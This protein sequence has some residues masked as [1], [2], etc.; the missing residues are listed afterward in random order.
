MVDTS[1]LS[2]YNTDPMDLSRY[3]DE[4]IKEPLLGKEEERDLFLELS[5]E[6]LPESRKKQIKDRI[7]RSNLRFV[8]KE[9]KRFSKSDP[10]LFEELISAGNEGLLVG[11]EKY[12]PDSGYRFLTYAGWWVKQRIL[13]QMSSQRL[14]ALPVWRQQLSS[15]IQKVMDSNEEITFDQLQLQFPEIPE[16]DLK[17]LFQTR[18]LTFYIE[19]MGDDPAFEINPI[20]TQVNIKLD[21]EFVHKAVAR[22]PTLQRKFIEM[23]FGLIDGEESKPADIMKEL[24]LSRDKYKELKKLALESLKTTFGDSSS[25]L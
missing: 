20:E 17:E 7:I 18:F 1:V 10:S 15:R 22:L 19:D 6:G 11:L 3:Y 25:Y 5:D 4:I 9:A 8:F 24:G 16:K 12:N 23:S 2:N 14:V 21:Q 13:S